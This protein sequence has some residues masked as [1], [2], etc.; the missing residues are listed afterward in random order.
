MMAR[1]VNLS[2]RPI[3]IHFGSCD[4]APHGQVEMVLLIFSR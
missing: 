2:S 1:S 3:Y 4:F